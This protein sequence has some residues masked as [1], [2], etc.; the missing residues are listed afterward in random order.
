MNRELMKKEAVD[1]MHKLNLFPTAIREFEN[2]NKLNFSFDGITFWLDDAKKKAVELFE[3]QYD[4]L[5]YH[6]IEDHHKINGETFDSINLLYVSS[7]ENEWEMERADLDDRTPLAY[8]INDAAHLKEIGSI[9]ITVN[10]IGGVA[11]VA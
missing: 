10:C 11:R 1:R 8:V 3:K 4:A 9:H 2:E 6:V 7:N 5:V